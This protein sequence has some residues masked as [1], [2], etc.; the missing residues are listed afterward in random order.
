VRG[1]GR[2]SRVAV[3]IEDWWDTYLGHG[4]HARDVI[5]EVVCWLILEKHPALRTTRF[6]PSLASKLDSGGF[7]GNQRHH[8]ASSRRVHRGEATSCGACD[9]QIKILGVGPF[10]HN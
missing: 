9:R 7:G 4:R 8:M 3:T 1:R 6:R 5:L 10:R 2:A